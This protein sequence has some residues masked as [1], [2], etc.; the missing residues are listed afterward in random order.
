[1]SVTV[2]LTIKKDRSVYTKYVQYVLIDA[3]LQLEYS[4]MFPWELAETQN[5]REVA[6]GLASWSRPAYRL[7][8]E[9]DGRPSC[10][11]RETETTAVENR[12]PVLGNERGSEKRWTCWGAGRLLGANKTADIPSGGYCICQPVLPRGKL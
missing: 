7:I 8:L 5:V 10:E 3:A 1:M 4:F 11:L 6:A 2:F 12:C 9:G